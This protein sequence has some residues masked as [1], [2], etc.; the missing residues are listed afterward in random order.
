QV[1]SAITEMSSTVQEVGR[2]VASAAQDAEEADA[3]AVQGREVVNQTKQAIGQLA[4][5][6]ER[7]AEVIPACRKK[8]TILVLCWK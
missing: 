8:A 5:E 4:A 7:A 2:N 3:Q 1:A 6:I